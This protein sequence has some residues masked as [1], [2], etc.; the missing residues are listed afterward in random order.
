[1]TLRLRSRMPMAVACGAVRPGAHRRGLHQQPRRHRG[2]RREDQGRDGGVGAAAIERP[3]LHLPVR[4]QC[5]PQHLNNL[6][7]AQLMYRPLYWFGAGAQPLLNPSLSLANPPTWSANTATITLK[8][9]T[10]SNGS[11]VTTAD[12]M[13]WINSSRTEGGSDRLRR[14]Q[15][16]P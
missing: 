13:F 10:W 1:M 8:H 7:F 3:E 9:Y 11:P 5:L 4:E 2:R 12:V 16:L 15:R 6:S 14:L